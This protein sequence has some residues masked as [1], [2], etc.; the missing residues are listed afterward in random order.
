MWYGMVFQGNVPAAHGTV[1]WRVSIQN[2][3][4]MVLLVYPGIFTVRWCV[5]KN[6]L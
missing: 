5:V 2:V 6:M 1:R 4:V 3:G